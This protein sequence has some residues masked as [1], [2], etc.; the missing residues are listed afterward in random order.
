MR[1]LHKATKRGQK[2]YSHYFAKRDLFFRE[3][4][5]K[6]SVF[7]KLTCLRIKF[8]TSFGSFAQAP[9][10]KQKVGSLKGVLW[11]LELDQKAKQVSNSK[12]NCWSI[13]IILDFSYILIF[14]GL[15]LKF[16][17]KNN[18]SKGKNQCLK[19]HKFIKNCL[20]AFILWCCFCYQD[21]NVVKFSG[22]FDMPCMTIW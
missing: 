15:N 3:V 21:V 6:Q 19:A 11:G 9:P 10:E 8:F 2:F 16:Q 18:Q 17:L 5:K 7:A 1:C 14:N 12:L 20:I 13:E 22:D 4:K